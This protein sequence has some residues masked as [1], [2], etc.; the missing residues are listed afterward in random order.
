MK[1]IY[2]FL[3]LSFCFSSQ[4]YYNPESYGV[5]EEEEEADYPE[6]LVG[7]ILF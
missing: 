6:R 7:E 3:E 5:E 4:R 1:L 2:F